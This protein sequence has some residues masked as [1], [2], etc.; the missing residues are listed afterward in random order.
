MPFV[1]L[2]LAFDMMIDKRRDLLKIRV[3]LMGISPPIWREILVPARYSF[4]DLHVAVQDAMGWLDHHTHEITYLSVEPR[5]KGQR[6][7]KCIAGYRACPP[8]DCGGVHGYQSLL[9]VLF[10]PSHPEHESLSH[11]IPRGWGPELFKPENVRFDNP[12][13]RWEKAFTEAD[14]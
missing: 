12:L 8:D 9:G 7:P 4:W 14:R 3:E 6:Y 5:A 1:L 11:W 10:D 13:K 2:I